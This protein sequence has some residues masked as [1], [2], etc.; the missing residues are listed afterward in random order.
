MSDKYKLSHSARQAVLDKLEW[1]IRH[2][3]EREFMNALRKLGVKDEEPRFA[4]SVKA[5][6]AAK[7]GKL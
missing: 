1:L 2:G 4:E 6:R 7:S 3:D 5:F